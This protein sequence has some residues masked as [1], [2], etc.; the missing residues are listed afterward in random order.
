[1]LCPAGAALRGG[2]GAR[3]EAPGRRERGDRRRGLRDAEDGEARSASP[4]SPPPAPGRSR[5]T[6]RGMRGSPAIV[7]WGCAVGVFRGTVRRGGFERRAGSALW[8]RS[9]ERATA[10]PQGAG[11]SRRSWSWPCGGWPCRCGG[12]KSFERAS[13]PG[14]RLEA[15]SVEQQRR[16]Q[17]RQYWDTTNWV[18]GM[19]G[20]LKG[21]RLE[22]GE[23]NRDEASSLSR[24][25]FLSLSLHTLSFSLSTLPTRGRGQAEA[26]IETWGAGCG[27]DGVDLLL[28]LR[29]HHDICGQSAERPSTAAYAA[30]GVQ[31]WLV[32][33]F[34][35][36]PCLSEQLSNLLC[37][38]LGRGRSF[39]VTVIV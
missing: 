2:R 7:L 15:I 27:G 11:A 19:Q 17:R 23:A 30:R 20:S 29:L 38:A 9:G 35:S 36:V 21:W 13:L 25:F 26:G 32:S 6:V 8:I 31:A 14:P 3:R 5:G 12:R 24:S 39:S 4:I 22:S 18:K 34:L 37:G 1:V 28:S 10:V 16:R 33:V